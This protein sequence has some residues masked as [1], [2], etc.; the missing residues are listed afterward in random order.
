MAGC[1]VSPEEDPVQ[2]KLN[3]LDTRLA[4]IER[5]VANQSSLDLANQNE[6]LRADIR[7]MHNDVD[8]LTNSLEASRKQQRDL[9]ADL[10]RRMKGLEGARCC[11]PGRGGVRAMRVAQRRRRQVPVRSE[12]ARAMPADRRLREQR[13]PLPR[14]RTTRP[15]IKPRFPC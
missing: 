7:A 5:V 6:A 10:D 12:P 14:A 9:Y 11:G 8:Q 1:A 3:D 4:R 15:A 13:A 2:I